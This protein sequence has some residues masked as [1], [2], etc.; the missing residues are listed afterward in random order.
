M[1]LPSCFELKS[2]F[3]VKPIQI[4]E[5][6]KEKSKFVVCEENIDSSSKSEKSNSSSVELSIS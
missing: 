6:I 1:T 5:M 4:P 3:T 2:N